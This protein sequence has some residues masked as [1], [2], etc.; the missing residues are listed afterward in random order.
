MPQHLD[1]AADTHAAPPPSGASALLHERVLVHEQRVL[2]LEALDRQVGGVGHVHLDTVESVG[3]G[4]AAG[5]AA[6]GL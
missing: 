4:G 6:D 5:A 2:R 3:A 1:G